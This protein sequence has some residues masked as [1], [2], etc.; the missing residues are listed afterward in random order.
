MPVDVL[1]LLRFGIRQ[2]DYV[3][4]YSIIFSIFICMEIFHL[5]I[6][7][8][9]LQIGHRTASKP[10]DL[11]G[12]ALGMITYTVCTL[13]AAVWLWYRLFQFLDIP[14][15]KIVDLLDIELPQSTKV[16]VDK[17]TQDSITLHWENEPE[18]I[19]LSLSVDEMRHRFKVLSYKLYLD[20]KLV[21]NFPN[22]KRT[23]TCVSLQGLKC[24]TQYQVD[25]V[26]V[27]QL[28]F[29]N[30]LPN[31]FVMTLPIDSKKP[32]DF[33][34]F[35]EYPDEQ[36]MDEV[37]TLIPA[38]A[39]WRKPL[40]ITQT[41]KTITPSYSSLTTLNDLERFSIQDLKNI[42]VCSQEDLHDVLQQH[43]L[44]LQDFKDSKLQLQM[45]LD[46]LKVQWN[47]EI[48]LRKSMKS[49]INSLESSKLL[50]DLK[51]E[52]LERSLKQINQKIEK[53]NN[54]MLAW[55]A[56][57]DIASKKSAL[58]DKYK[59]LLQQL[60]QQM[61]ETSKQI[62]KLQNEVLEQEDENKRLNQLKKYM[63]S[64]TNSS[65][66][67]AQSTDTLPF[68]WPHF[69]KKIN[70][71]TIS[72]SGLLS[73]SGEDLLKNAP[74]QS[75]FIQLVKTELDVDSK[76]ENQWKYS[77]NKYNRRIEQLEKVWKDLQS[78]NNQYKNELTVKA[79][80][81]S[82][83]PSQSALG[84]DML[85]QHSQQSQ[86]P[87]QPQ[88]LQLHDP[89][90]YSNYNTTGSLLAQT[91][92][93]ATFTS[94][95]QQD[96]IT[97][98]NLPGQQNQQSPVM[99]A[100]GPFY[101]NIE[102]EDSSHL[103]SG[104]ENMVSEVGDKPRSLMPFTNDQ[105]DDYWNSTNHFYPSTY[106]VSQNAQ[107]Q[108]LQLQQ[109]DQQ[110]QQQQ[111]IAPQ[112]ASISSSQSSLSPAPQLKQPDRNIIGVLNDNANDDVI[113]FQ[114]ALNNGP[115]SS[116]MIIPSNSMHA[117]TDAA[118]SPSFHSIWN[119]NRVPTPNSSH[120]IR[121][122]SQQKSWIFHEPI[123][124]SIENTDEKPK[125]TPTRRMSKLFAKG[126]QLFKLP[127]HDSQ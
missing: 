19:D 8:K 99:A 103:L 80:A 45:E 4:F 64:D 25:L 27:N 108:Q 75:P 59:T 14:I 79:Y 93:S 65:L 57:S 94:W 1:L 28:G 90:S 9:Q 35:S 97:Q 60:D 26:T 117:V 24:G 119:D 84:I 34:L 15:F 49:T 91:V 2:V 98:Q 21:A 113:S 114:S 106:P 12:K 32:S 29:T 5:R 13:L 112:L 69:L 6:N 83:Q 124:S 77:K 40:L 53:M 96:Q 111:L 43:S 87:Q 11:S 68:N 85:P 7:Y 100:E 70:D 86:Q 121:N 55:S 89:A 51:R 71:S 16:S 50:Y 44:T 101:Q 22:T 126:T 116:P 66:A 109:Q 47:H 120:H 41:P 92:A 33:S 58:E 81:L 127:S 54:D 46:N 3:R 20:G 63:D 122:E 95:L 73:Q 31:L 104:L 76:L 17:I 36:L 10:Q 42:L 48:E 38:D 62:K 61:D 107:T 118:F 56:D 18:S 110:Q 82:Q 39:K 23:Y 67:Q 52:K 72:K 123:D 88:Q 102:Y 105:L 115:A 78:K 74:E 125:E 37:S 30:K